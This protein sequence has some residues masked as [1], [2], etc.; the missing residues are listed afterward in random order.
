MSGDSEPAA[1]ALDFLDVAAGSEADHL[2]DEPE[3]VESQ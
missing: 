3:G 2:L 1:L